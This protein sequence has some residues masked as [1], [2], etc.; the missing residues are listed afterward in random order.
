MLGVSN[1]Y[2][3]EL[4]KVDFKTINY[5]YNDFRRHINFYRYFIDDY[6]FY[7]MSILIQSTKSYCMY[8]ACFTTI[9]FS[10]DC[11]NNDFVSLN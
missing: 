8:N 11:F 6:D 9:N 10:C 2:L 5:N 7:L 3:Y 1:K 4:Y